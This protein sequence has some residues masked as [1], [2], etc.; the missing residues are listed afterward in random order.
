MG[1]VKANNTKS[2]VEIFLDQPNVYL[3]GVGVDVEPTRISGHVAVYLTESTSIKEITLNFKGKA[4]L[5]IPASEAYVL[6]LFSF[7]SLIELM[8]FTAKQ[9]DE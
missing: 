9:C 6:Y 3:K 1:R 8:S 2:R 4:T 5:P 7:S